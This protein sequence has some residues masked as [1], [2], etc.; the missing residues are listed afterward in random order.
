MGS[1]LLD[2]A[3]PALFTIAYTVGFVF[4][5]YVHARK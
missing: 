3:V 5:V 2:N 1:E 4:L